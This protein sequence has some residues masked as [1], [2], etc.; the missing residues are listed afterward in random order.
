[1]Q[2][3]VLEF[4]ERPGRPLFHLEHFMDGLY[5][6]YNSNSGYVADEKARQTPQV[7][8][9]IFSPVPY[10]RIFSTVGHLSTLLRQAFFAKLNLIL[11]IR[12]QQWSS[13]QPQ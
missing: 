2:M 7:D 13:L 6:K 12:T 11:H 4:S 5:I 3:A 9:V 1:M 8:G 10:E